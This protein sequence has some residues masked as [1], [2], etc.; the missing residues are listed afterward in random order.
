MTSAAASLVAQMTTIGCLPVRWIVV[1]VCG[2]R[3]DAFIK[4]VLRIFYSKERAPG[5][6]ARGAVVSRNAPEALRRIS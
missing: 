6:W 2:Q 3:P 1:R 4:R 5:C